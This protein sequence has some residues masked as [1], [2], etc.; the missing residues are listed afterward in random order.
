MG[1]T[2]RVVHNTD[3]SSDNDKMTTFSCVP[4]GDGWDKQKIQQFLVDMTGKT[5]IYH[6]I[7][8]EA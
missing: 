8:T 1:L 4:L 5:Q 6:P 2:N 7:H 3:D